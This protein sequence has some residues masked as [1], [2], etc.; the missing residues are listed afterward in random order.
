[1]TPK[2]ASGLSDTHVRLVRSPVNHGTAVAFIRRR[3]ERDRS[4]P[5][6]LSE[7]IIGPPIPERSDLWARKNRVDVIVEGF[8]YAPHGSARASEVRLRIE[9]SRGARLDRTIAVFGPRHV[10]RRSGAL[11]FSEPEPFERMAID[12][13]HAYGG[14]D[15]RVTIPE[16]TLLTPAA[17]I[18]HPGLYPRNRAGKGYCV[19]EP[20]EGMALPELEDPSDLLS[21]DRITVGDPRN[22]HT[23]PLPW[24]FDWSGPLTFPR[25]AW[26]SMD[27]WYP[28][29]PGAT[30]AEVARGF[31]PADFRDRTEGLQ[32][33]PEYFQE[34]SPGMMMERI[35][36]GEE[37]SIT[38]MH[39]TKETIPLTLPCPPDVEIALD[40][41][42]E[43]V[44][45]RAHTLIFR[46]HEESFSIVYAAQR[47]LNRALIGGIHRRFP[48]TVRVD[49]GSEVECVAPPTA[50][51]VVGHLGAGR[52]RPS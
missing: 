9:G 50:L 22:W 17:F 38:G 49:G 8:A 31:L 45:V 21:P 4:R 14:I 52:S 24:T 43:S 10:V 33:A 32:M 7:G 3:F 5:E 15:S 25:C 37:I 19:E 27:A 16:G 11:R 18:D 41:Q 29:P 36:G 6:A 39:P 35:E 1:M 13:E 51:D 26:A 47:P 40:G 44:E 42:A 12:G 34:A 48:V 28:A 30:F 46:P 23:M 20:L 2:S